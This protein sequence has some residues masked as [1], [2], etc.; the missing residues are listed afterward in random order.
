MT[1]SL[2]FAD[3]CIVTIQPHPDDESSKAAATVARYA[4]LGARVVLI[5]CT[6]GGAGTPTSDGTPLAVQRSRELA[7]AAALLGFAR[8]VHLGYRDSGMDASVSDGFS[9]RPIDPIIDEVA[10]LLRSEQPHAVI[11]FDPDYASRHPDHQRAYD[12]AVAAFR[13]STDHTASAQRL[14]G[15][16]THSPAK[17]AALHR[18]LTAESRP[19]PYT[20]ALANASMR[21]DARIEVG[22]YVAVAHAALRAHTSQV[23]ADDPW[24]FS[25]PTDVQAQI[26][27]YEDFELLAGP[28][29]R[30][31]ELLD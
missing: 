14:Y 10:A 13:R 19:S 25:V 8:V 6:D 16:R 3:R 31:G 21:V 2:P 12:V 11:T 1:T 9:T 30:A 24:F 22:G 28:P 23:P 29:A 27:P 4:A 7:H 5:C 20:N 15:T 26:Y 17:L 18:W